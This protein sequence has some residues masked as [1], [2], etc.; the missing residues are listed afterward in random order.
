MV[1]GL[2]GVIGM[3]ALNL[4]EMEHQKEQEIALIQNH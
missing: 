2:N 4:V 3:N 1:D